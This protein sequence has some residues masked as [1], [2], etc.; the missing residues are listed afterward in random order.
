[1]NPYF[2]TNQNPALLSFGIL[3]YRWHNVLARRV[4]LKHPTWSDEDIFQVFFLFCLMIYLNFKTS[5]CSKIEHSDPSKYHCIW[6]SA[7]LSWRLSCPVQWLSPWPSSRHIACL[8]IR[9]LPIWAYPYS[10]WNLQTWWKVQFSKRWRWIAS[11]KT[12]LLLVGCLGHSHRDSS[13]GSLQKN[14]RSNHWARRCY[15][16]FWYQKQAL[17]SARFFSARSCCFKHHEGER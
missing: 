4:Q 10:T 7:C 6:I 3:F 9:S 15:S 1:M 2:R 12:V 16:L 17:W 8:P 13:W 14:E 11:S 5:E